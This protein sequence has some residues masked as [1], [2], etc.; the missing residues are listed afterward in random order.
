MNNTG[1]NELS[2]WSTLLHLTL[3]VLSV[4]EENKNLP[5][6]EAANSVTVPIWPR[7]AD[8]CSYVLMLKACMFLL[9]VPINN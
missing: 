4:E 9:Y 6:G 5:D 3:T 7:N 2:R 1:V 8:T